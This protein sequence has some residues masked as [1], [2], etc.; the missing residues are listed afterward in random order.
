[1]NDKYF[2]YI[3]C[4]GGASGILLLKALRQDDFF[5]DQ[6]ILIV[7]KELKRVMIEHGAIGKSQM[8]NLT[9]FFHKNG[10]EHNLVQTLIQVSLI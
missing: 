5:K 10:I 8:E 9:Q 1:M 3:I 2:D 7:D 4:G 6:T